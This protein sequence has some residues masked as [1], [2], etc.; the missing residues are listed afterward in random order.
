MLFDYILMKILLLYK[1]TETAEMNKQYASKTKSDTMGEA[2]IVTIDMLT[3]PV[4]TFAKRNRNN[5]LELI[6]SNDSG[7]L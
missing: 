1:K 4:D 7:T 3:K 6:D 2:S 5:P